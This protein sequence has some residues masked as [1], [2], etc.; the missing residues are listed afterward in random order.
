MACWGPKILREDQAGKVRVAKDKMQVLDCPGTRCTRA[1][2]DSSGVGRWT[3]AVDPRMGGT[4]SLLRTSTCL[5]V[6]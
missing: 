4:Y 5:K 6:G 1:D 3:G 2:A